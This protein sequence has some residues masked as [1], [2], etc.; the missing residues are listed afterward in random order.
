[1]YQLKK[2]TANIKKDFFSRLFDNNNNHDN[3]S[4]T[5]A[6]SEKARKASE[7]CINEVNKTIKETKH[8]DG[9]LIQRV[10]LKLAKLKKEVV[11]SS[12]ILFIIFCFG[13]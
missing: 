11:C 4:A 12:F 9:T 7:T 3:I 13:F 6:A 1:M 10:D 2:K 5:L 8:D